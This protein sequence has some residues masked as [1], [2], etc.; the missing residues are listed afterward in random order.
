MLPLYTRLSHAPITSS[1]YP[2]LANA[3]ILSIW[4]ANYTYAGAATN[5]CSLLHLMTAGGEICVVGPFNY[6][7]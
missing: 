7:T 3:S 4:C 2:R 5:A 1:T 6:D